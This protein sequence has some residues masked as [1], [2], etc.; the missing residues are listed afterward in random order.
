MHRET[1]LWL[2]IDTLSDWAIGT[3]KG[4]Y[5]SLDSMV[6]RD[7]Q[8]LPLCR[9][10]RSRGCCVM[11]VSRWRWLWTMVSLM[12]GGRSSISS[13]GLSRLLTHLVPTRTTSALPAAFCV[14][15]RPSWALGRTAR[16]AF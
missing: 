7:A 6:A 13:S 10:R 15:V 8:G 12:L 14:L 5:G 4:R 1:P 11:P 2:H 9:L 3:G 16:Q